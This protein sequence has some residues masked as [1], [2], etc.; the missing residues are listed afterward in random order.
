M[1]DTS[2]LGRVGEVLLDIA[3]N[4]TIG[5]IATRARVIDGNGI[6]WALSAVNGGSTRN[7]GNH[8]CFT[9]SEKAYN[10]EERGEGSFTSLGDGLG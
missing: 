7:V 4:G 9:Q 5:E 1:A 3:T 2:R 6:G 8:R 10:R